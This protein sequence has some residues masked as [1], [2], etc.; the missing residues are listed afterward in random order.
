MGYSGFIKESLNVT[1]YNSTNYRKLNVTLNIVFPMSFTVNSS[2]N[3]VVLSPQNATYSGYYSEVLNN[4]TCAPHGSNSNTFSGSLSGHLTFGIAAQ[5][6][7]TQ[8]VVVLQFDQWGGI[9]GN[10]LPDRCSGSGPAFPSTPDNG[11]GAPGYLLLGQVM[12]PNESSGVMS[13]IGKGQ[14][15]YSNPYDGAFYGF[16]LNGYQGQSLNAR[17]SGLLAYWHCTGESACG[18]GFRDVSYVMVVNLNFS[19]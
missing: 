13:Q 12:G 10:G 15:I 4:M 3:L 2:G 8:G 16:L 1:D 5:F 9:Y 17:Y 11:L 7:K 14:R 19:S 6:N 18:G